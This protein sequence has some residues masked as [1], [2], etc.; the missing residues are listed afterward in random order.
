[1]SRAPFEEGRTVDVE[2]LTELSAH[3]LTG[4]EKSLPP[5]AQA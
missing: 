5:G 3:R 2:R 4:F 1:M